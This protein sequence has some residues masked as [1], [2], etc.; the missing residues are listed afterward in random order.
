MPVV[1]PTILSGGKAMDPTYELASVHVWTEVNRVPRAE[2][3]VLDGDAAQ[4]RFAVSDTSFFVPGANIEIRVRYEGEADHSIFEGIVVRHGVEATDRGSVLV[5]GIKDACVKLA[6]V[7]RSAVFRGKT[8]DTIIKELIT[9]AGVGVGSVEQTQPAHAE[10]VQYRCTAWD[11]IL[12]RADA[13][14][15]L[16]TADHGKVSLRKMAVKS[17]PKHYFEWGINEIYDIDIEID[18]DHQYASVEAIG[19]NPRALAPTAP[20]KARSAPPT[21]GNL[22][23]A[24]LAKAVGRDRCTLSHLV[25]AHAAEL[26]AWADATLD[27]SR[28]AMLR[29]RLTVPGFADIQPLDTMELAGIG[30]RF[31]GVTLVTGVHHQI[32]ESGWQTDVQ[33][34][35]SPEPFAQAP[36]IV[37][38][39]AA[40][41][42]PAVRALQLG[43]VAN[44]EEDPQKELR[45]KVYLPGV[46]AT[47]GGAVWAQLACPDAG[48]GHGYYFRPEPGDE[49][50]VG[51]LDADPR[52][53]VIL[54]RK[55]ATR[56]TSRRTRTGYRVL[57]NWGEGS[58]TSGPSTAWRSSV[59]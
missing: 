29:G 31:N 14:G 51:F 6:G 9:A 22:D 5:I 24:K 19:W 37:E 39:P 11:F 56:C 1:T 10:M 58:R 46:D 16:V 20:S 54:G 26:Q 12:S 21:P 49:V 42:L 57:S 41:L 40:G 28:L 35:L 23:A 59:C 48:N 27:R 13:Q 38:T 50:V 4:R 8:D 33:F 45:V 32:D 30:K 17:N 25:P 43:V 47:T 15:L 36:H 34:G 44:F 55:S 3:R 53:A 18:A 7:R 2:L 52:C